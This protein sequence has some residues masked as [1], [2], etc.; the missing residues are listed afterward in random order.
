MATAI[1]LWA[2]DFLLLLAPAG[3]GPGEN[4]C[5]LDFLAEVWQ[6]PGHERLT[7]KGL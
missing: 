3:Y 1:E 5:L 2:S 4:L 6:M 7:W